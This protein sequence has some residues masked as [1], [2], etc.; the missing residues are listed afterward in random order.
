MFFRNKI[1]ELLPLF[2]EITHSS[3]TEALHVLEGVLSPI[4][5]IPRRD[6]KVYKSNRSLQELLQALIQKVD[7]NS[8]RP[9]N[10]Y[11]VL[12]LIN[13][14]LRVENQ[15]A[16]A[17]WSQYCEEQVEAVNEWVTTLKNTL[18]VENNPLCLL[19]LIY[20]KHSDTP[21]KFAGWL[22]YFLYRGKTSEEIIASGFLH[23]N[24]D[25]N[26]IH[27]GELCKG[28]EFFKAALKLTDQYYN[29]GLNL[30]FL[31]ESI[32][33][34]RRGYELLALD[35]SLS[36]S[37][38]TLGSRNVIGMR[39]R[40]QEMKINFTPDKLNLSK[41]HAFFGNSLL[42]YALTSIKGNSSNIIRKWCN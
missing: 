6:A 34:K 3:L 21:I 33:A 1:I 28:Y 29:E 18:N 31:A 16:F 41:L 11:D 4:N 2:P 8:R 14:N 32:S 23:D 20:N 7:R 27:L 26:L 17:L 42:F 36:Q 38:N 13:T 30:L 39:E 12:S 19:P 22:I 40:S 25:L 37:P 9:D 5:D 15:Y 10:V 35:T 24:F